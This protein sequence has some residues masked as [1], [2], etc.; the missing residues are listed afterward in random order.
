MP[1][2]V[3]VLKM[4]KRQVR[5]FR[6]GHTTTISLTLVYQASHPASVKVRWFR[7]EMRSKSPLLNSEVPSMIPID[8]E[9]ETALDI[10]DAN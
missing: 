6:S 3:P 9:F 8:G 5:H 2:E 10:S 1:S 4:L 7:G